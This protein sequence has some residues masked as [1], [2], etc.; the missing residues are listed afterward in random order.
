LPSRSF[1]LTDPA[2][3]IA[4]VETLFAVTSLTKLV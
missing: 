1:P 4:A 2:A 3:V